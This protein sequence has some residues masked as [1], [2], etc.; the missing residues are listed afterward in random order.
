MT[1][2]RIIITIQCLF[3]CSHLY[4]VSS[5]NTAPSQKTSRSPAV[6]R[7]S[8]V[9]LLSSAGV[10]SS[11]AAVLADDVESTSPGSEVATRATTISYDDFLESLFRGTAERV[12]FYGSEGEEVILT[13]KSGD[14]LQVLGVA[15]ES[16]NS[17]RGPLSTVAKVRD[18]KVPLSFESFDLK[19][20][21][22]GKEKGEGTL[23]VPKYV[24]PFEDIN[25]SKARE[26]KKQSGG[27]S[28][29]PSFPSLPSF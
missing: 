3:L 19:S 1:R 22:K 25:Q 4:E 14:R 29:I 8:F 11:A 23:E 2:I 15:K 6:S 28:W 18:A 21:R 26:L 10:T 9:S 17:P 24:N 12:Q 5:Y 16:A 20:F 27:Q 13:T 7:R